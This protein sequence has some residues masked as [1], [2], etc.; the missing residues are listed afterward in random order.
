MWHGRGFMD[1]I[2][3]SSQGKLM[4]A[5]PQ[6]KQYE[7]K[8]DILTDWW[9][10]VALIG[11]INSHSHAS[12]I[13]SDMEDT[14]A[15][16]GDLHNKL[17]NNLLFEHV[18]KVIVDNTAKSQVTIDILI[19]NLFERTADVAFLATDDD[20][21]QFIKQI[22]VTNNNA[23]RSIEVN[24]KDALRLSIESRLQEYVKKYSVYDEIMILDTNGNV[25]AN[26]DK[27][28]E[29]VVCQ[30]SLV[31]ET[32]T[33]KNDYVETFRY[34]ELQPK[35]Q[36]SL[37]YSCKIT[38]NNE[39]DSL[40]LGVLCLCFRFNDEMN[41]IFNNLS[42]KSNNTLL[43]MNENDEVIA[44]SNPNLVPINRHFTF[45]QK[46]QFITYQGDEFLATSCRS[47]GYQDYF[48]LG[49]WAMS[50]SPVKSAFHQEREMKNSANGHILSSRLFSDELKE[51]Y[52]A[53]KIVNDDLSLVVLN[54][55]VT[56]LRQKA[57]EFMPVLEAIKEIGEST[58]NIFSDSINELQQTVISSH[59]DDV[60]F[61]AE[62]AINIMDRNLYERANDCRWWALTSDFQ[63]ILLKSTIDLDDKQKLSEILSYINELYT[64]YTNLYLFDHNEVIIA[65]SDPLQSTLVG[66][67]VMKNSG[68]TEVLRLT[69]SQEYIVSPFT[70]TPLYENKHT[71][72]Y[73]A[74]I[75]PEN[76]A[77]AVGGIGIVF[78]SG[79]EFLAI[80]EDT[81][82]KNEHGVINEGCFAI[83]AE[84]TGKIISATETSPCHVGQQLN[85]AAQLFDIEAGN[86]HSEVYSFQGIE[87]IL[88]VASSSGYR[89]YKTTEDYENDV[90]AFI[91]VPV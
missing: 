53:S 88:G 66:Q 7:T 29:V 72:I 36:A 56:S 14:K 60:A 40:V 70:K 43:L 16:F 77:S 81:L 83:F 12:I 62:L 41:A 80:L 65:V 10:K 91:F 54:G 17:I 24:D 78:D 90:L 58:A 35:K 69:A 25:L 76:V 19:R 67:K 30:D 75:I 3:K 15:K 45:N 49:W 74:A 32:L 22:Y 13:L 2:I 27:T 79:P 48:G 59:M 18:K 44:S 82:P 5:M 64:V 50:L 8:L 57:V 52:Q 37:I 6:V 89:E 33:S 9:G 68:S 42:E 61:M 39:P 51:I 26:L 21:R 34:S 31:N 84:R 73:N 28:N 4:S 55:Q 47:N 63:N 86:K 87:Y 85:L 71:Y 46:A 20:I 38:E 1:A 23:Q 11:K